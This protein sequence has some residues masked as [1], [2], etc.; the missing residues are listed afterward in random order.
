MKSANAI[1]YICCVQREA[2]NYGMQ[3]GLKNNLD[4]L[5]IVS[6]IVD[7]AVNE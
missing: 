2:V 5:N 6:S 4:I 1:D 3:I 7:F